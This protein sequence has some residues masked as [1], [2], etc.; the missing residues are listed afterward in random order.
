MIR[1]TPETPRHCVIEKPTLSEIR[2][3]IDKHVKN[4][5]LKKVQAPIGVKPIL[6]TWMELN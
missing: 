3:K 4:T 2:A 1:S 6:K 5:Y